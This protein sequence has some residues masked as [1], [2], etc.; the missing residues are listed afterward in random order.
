MSVF[1]YLRETYD[2]DVLEKYVETVFYGIYGESIRE[3]SAELCYLK[4]HMSDYKAEQVE[5]TLPVSSEFRKQ[6]EGLLQGMSSFRFTQGLEQLPREL[7]R[8]LAEKQCRILLRT[9]CE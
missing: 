6:T 7:Q 2:Q 5:R 4:E 9:S 1:D 3:L 8:Y